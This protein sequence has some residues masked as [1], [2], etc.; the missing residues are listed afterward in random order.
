M[1]EMLSGVKKR[2][3]FG[4]G[5]GGATVG[6]ALVL[7]SQFLCVCVCFLLFLSVPVGKSLSSDVVSVGV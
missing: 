2:R 6:K 7:H 3:Y 5:V 1:V 4:L